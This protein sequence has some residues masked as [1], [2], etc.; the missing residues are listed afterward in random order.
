MENFK[1]PTKHD[2][3]SNSSESDVKLARKKRLPQDTR[4]DLSPLSPSIALT[5]WRLPWVEVKEVW[6]EDITYSRKETP[7]RVGKK[8]KHSH[9]KERLDRLEQ[10]MNYLV[11]N[12]IGIC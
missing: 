8:G 4:L 6:G 9:S 11:E 5:L 7:K 12:Y 10:S 1:S 3:T 2:S